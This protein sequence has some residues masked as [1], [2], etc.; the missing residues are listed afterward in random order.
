MGPKSVDLPNQ[1][2]VAL[3]LYTLGYIYLNF[4]KELSDERFSAIQDYENYMFPDEKQALNKAI[5]YFEEAKEAFD[6]V[7]HLM[8]SYLSK[9]GQWQSKLN[10]V[11]ICRGADDDVEDLEEEA[12][13]LLSEVNELCG[14]VLDYHRESGGFEKCCF[15]PRDHGNEV[16]LMAEI[17]Y[18]KQQS[19]SLFPRKDG[20][21][22]FRVDNES[23]VSNIYL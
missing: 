6:Q 7:Q 19:L 21:D 10:I 18:R 2:G 5:D 16:S 22:A 8:G 1:Y 13:E 15:I 11:D 3:C 9:L 23:F 17:V 4:Q 14:K 20:E 12:T